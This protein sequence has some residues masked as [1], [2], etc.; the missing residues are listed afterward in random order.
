MVLKLYYNKSF[1]SILQVSI[2]YINAVPNVVVAVFADV[3]EVSH[4]QPLSGPS[5]TCVS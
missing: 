2:L 4:Q 1:N 5:T 3:T